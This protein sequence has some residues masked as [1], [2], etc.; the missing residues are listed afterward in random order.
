[1]E[2][3]GI[4]SRDFSLWIRG[5]CC[6][7]VVIHHYANLYESVAEYTPVIWKIF[8]SI[9][10][11]LGVGV[12]FFLSGY[13]VTESSKSKLLT[14]SQIL[15]SRYWK[16][17]WPILIV[18]SIYLI[19]RYLTFSTIDILNHDP[20]YYGINLK[21]VDRALWFVEVLFYC[22]ALFYI[23]CWIGNCIR[24][25][26]SS[27]KLVRF[28]NHAGRLIVQGLFFLG[29]AVIVNQLYPDKF[30]YYINIPMF[31][32]G[33]IYSEYRN[34]ISK[35]MTPLI[36]LLMFGLVLGVTVFF[37]FVHYIDLSHMG[38]GL[39]CVI[40]IIGLSRKYYVT[41]AYN[42]L[43]GIISMEI[44]ITHYKLLQLLSA[45]RTIIPSFW[46]FLVSSILIGLIFYIA[47]S[48]SVPRL[49]KNKDRSI[50]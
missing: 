48:L 13:G 21:G 47:F 11:F 9:G 26:D 46:L 25:P 43:L 18:N 4:I 7:L 27:I 28:W 42:S 17:L 23:Y 29:L 30:W 5:I 10:G 49:S 14:F 40:L 50:S 44:Y 19:Y 22:Y 32:L 38:Y 45:D 36:T 20:S 8:S 15:K 12:F 1:M 41:T 31:W 33:I 34:E 37:R 16:L 39:A 2:K 6:L 35:W 24:K 3:Q